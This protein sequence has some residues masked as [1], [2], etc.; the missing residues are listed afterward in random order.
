[1][2]WRQT[3]TLFLMFLVS[4]VDGVFLGDEGVVGS[5]SRRVIG[6]GRSGEAL[7][8]GDEGGFVGRKRV[9]SWLRLALGKF[10]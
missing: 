5:R 8:F 1:M 6:E 10:L 4:E 2:L 3:G 7:C 9:L